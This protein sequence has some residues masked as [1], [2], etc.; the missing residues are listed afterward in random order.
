M[1]L[2]DVLHQLL[3]IGRQ[4]DFSR[5]DDIQE[6]NDH[7]SVCRLADALR[8]QVID[9]SDSQSTDDKIALIKSI[10]MLEHR[11][12]GLGSVTLLQY[13]VPLGLSN[14]RSLID[15]ILHNTTSYWYY[16]RS[17]R[18]VDELDEINKASAASAAAANRRNQRR[19]QEDKR[20]IADTATMNLFNAVR[21]GD[22]KAVRGLMAK[23]ANPYT[24][25]PDGSRLL[26]FAAAKG[27]DAV[28]LELRESAFRVNQEIDEPNTTSERH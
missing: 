21:R 15:W 13:L 12:G 3:E 27:F 20:R 10:A 24:N 26:D 6:F 9:F 4:G 8:D 23:G 5:L 19:Q 1:I 22:A 25:T 11:V 2:S 16:T 28:V 18:S 17:A 14:D 7:H